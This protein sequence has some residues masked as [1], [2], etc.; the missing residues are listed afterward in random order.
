MAPDCCMIYDGLVQDCS[1]SS[2]SAMKMRGSLTLS[3]Q[4]VYNV[5]ILKHCMVDVY[6]WIIYRIHFHI[7]SLK[8][9]ITMNWK[10]AHLL[11]FENSNHTKS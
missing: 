1:I 9:G 10:C 8:F 3:Y 5:Q 7:Y 11:L 4:Y 2:V 6:C